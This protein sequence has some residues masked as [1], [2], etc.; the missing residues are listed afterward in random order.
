[1]KLQ[2]AMD[3]S[4]SGDVEMLAL[5]KSWWIHAGPECLAA[6][7]AFR[8]CEANHDVVCR[9]GYDAMEA[10]MTNCEEVPEI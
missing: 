8:E 5:M 10:A 9:C 6:L 2:D 3:R 4:N 7:K 1:M